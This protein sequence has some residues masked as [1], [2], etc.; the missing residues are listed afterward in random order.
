MC[1]SGDLGPPGEDPITYDV[2][3]CQMPN[4]EAVVTQRPALSLRTQAVPACTLR[5]C[6]AT[7]LSLYSS[8]LPLLP[9]I[10]P[11]LSRSQSLPV[12]PVPSISIFVTLIVGLTLF[13]R[14]LPPYTC[15]LLT[16]PTRP[17]RILRCALVPSSISPS[18]NPS[19]FSILSPGLPLLWTCA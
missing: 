15:V 11:S 12:L 19:F 7:A 1:S 5:I 14:S 16:C 9:A 6:A 17:R 4:G 2:V 10:L 18:G 13:S 8:T 3:S